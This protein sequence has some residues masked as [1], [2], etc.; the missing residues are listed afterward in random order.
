MHCRGFGDLCINGLGLEGKCSR[1][2][3]GGSDNATTGDTYAYTGSSANTSGG[4]GKLRTSEIRSEED[5][6]TKG[7]GDYEENKH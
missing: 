3:S 7:E 2:T 4:R 1:G 5:A 6:K